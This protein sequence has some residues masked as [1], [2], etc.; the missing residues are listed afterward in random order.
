MMDKKAPYGFDGKAYH[1][2][3]PFC[4]SELIRHAGLFSDR[5]KLSI[6]CQCGAS[7]TYDVLGFTAHK[8]L[9]E[10]EKS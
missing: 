10:S 2:T 3:C 1:I 7:I 8:A 6:T 5:N 4:E 9:E